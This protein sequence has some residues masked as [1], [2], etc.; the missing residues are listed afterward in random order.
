MQKVRWHQCHSN[1]AAVHLSG[2]IF[3]YLQLVLYIVYCSC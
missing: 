3:Y 1:D 2:A